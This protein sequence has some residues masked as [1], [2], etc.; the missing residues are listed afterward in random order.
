MTRRHWRYLGKLRG[1]NIC[2][3]WDA[4][5]WRIGAY[6]GRYCL[7]ANFGPLTFHAYPDMEMA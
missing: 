6:F 5:D 1:W 3:E 2:A 7:G 4:R